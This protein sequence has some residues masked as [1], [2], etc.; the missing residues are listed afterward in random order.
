LD[1][2]NNNLKLKPEEV[3]WNKVIFSYSEVL[4]GF[5]EVNKTIDKVYFL[6]SNHYF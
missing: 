4:N 2:V 6:S 3:D 1:H 5:I